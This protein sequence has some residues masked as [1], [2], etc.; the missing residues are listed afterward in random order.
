VPV[1]HIRIP[2]SEFDADDLLWGGKE[3]FDSRS[4]RIDLRQMAAHSTHERLIGGKIYRLEPGDLVTSERGLERRWGWSR[5]RVARFL[6]RLADA[7]WLSIKQS[8]PQY[9]LTICDHGACVVPR[10][11]DGT[12]DEPPTVPQTSHIEKEGEEGKKEKKKRAPTEHVSTRVRASRRMP[13]DYQFTDAE[14][15]ELRSL[16]GECG[17]NFETEL[18][19]MR[20]YEFRNPRSDW[21]A[22]ARNWLRKAGQHH[23]SANGNGSGGGRSG[24][25][26]Q[27]GGDSGSGGGGEVYELG[28]YANL[29]PPD[30][31][32]DEGGAAAA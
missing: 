27:G 5:G 23:G 16:A 7:H 10:T 24:S 29:P 25:R 30:W 6:A 9:H 26:G 2:R 12:A 4:A 20:D 31:A 15:Q 17:V 14:E 28:K 8:R 18:A 13:K 22:T 3:P 32:E 19:Q 11:T 1:P 21:P